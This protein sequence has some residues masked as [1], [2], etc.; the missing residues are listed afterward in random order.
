MTLTDIN[1]G[2]TY[3]ELGLNIA[4]YIPVT[5]ERSSR[6]REVYGNAMVIAALSSSIFLF[7]SA[8][9]VPNPAR[10]HQLQ[11]YSFLAF[12]YAIHGVLN[13]GRSFIEQVPYLSLG[14]CFPYDM[15]VRQIYPYAV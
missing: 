9:V 5:C 1:I 10:H 13:V 4:G 2:L 11:K 7:F 3:F 15:F 6:V 8:L 12:T 14:I